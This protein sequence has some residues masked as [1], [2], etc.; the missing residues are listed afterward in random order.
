[1]PSSSG[2]NPRRGEIWMVSLDPT[3]GDEMQ[4]TRPAVVLNSDELTTGQPPLSYF[5]IA[6]NFTSSARISSVSRATA[7]PARYCGT[8]P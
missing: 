2:V 5:L 6:S 1:M 8:P 7:G 4:K 3:L